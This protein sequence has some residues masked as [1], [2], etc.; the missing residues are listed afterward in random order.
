MPRLRRALGWPT[1]T[2][3]GVG[4]I[5]GAGI[6]SVIGAAA[7]EAG[8][9]VWL[10]FVVSAVVAVI[11][12]LS[13]AELATMFPNAGAE[14]VYLRKALPGRRSIAFTTGTLMAVSG[15][16]TTATV[17]LAFS[18]YLGA[19]VDVPTAIVAPL[20][21]IILTGVAIAG[22]KESALTT[23]LFTCVETI[24]LVLVIAAGA[25]SERFGEALASTPTFGMIPGAALVFFS[26]LGFENIAN[27]AEESKKPDRD[28]PRAILASVGIA[29]VL[30]VLVAL[31][32]VALLPAPELAA[33]DA[34]LADAVRVRSPMLATALGAI[35]LFATA[36]TALA[37]IISGSR[38]LYAMAGAN[39][40]PRPMGRLLPG[41]RTPWAATV[42]VGVGGLLLLPLGGV[43]VVASLS[44][45]ASLVAFAAV[46]V[47]IV[48]LR[49]RSPSHRRPFRVPWS[50]RGVPVPP[51]IGTLAIAVLLTQLD[52]TAIVSGV[53]LTALTLGIHALVRAAR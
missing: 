33:S 45:F 24:G 12:A 23:V 42:L 17:S 27:L 2:A 13:Y 22:V 10:A 39:E 38:I 11:T 5:L 34:P 48:L 14:F 35:A 16:A 8:E 37:A 15:A 29:T 19:F 41:R 49:R 28:L 51:V 30:Y 4:A 44:S 7:M 20:L 32:A 36:N 1:L 53:I 31:A 52:G 43:A 50:I 25:S 21:I 18:G 26:Y 40:L 6:Y 47:S 9:G 46:N 3:Y